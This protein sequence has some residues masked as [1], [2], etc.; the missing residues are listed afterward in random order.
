M[1]TIAIITAITGAASPS[2]AQ[3]LPPPLVL[4][5]GPAPSSP[6]SILLDPVAETTC[7]DTPVQ[8][9]YRED[10]PPAS[11]SETLEGPQTSVFRFA[12]AAD[13]RTRD[14]R[15]DGMAGS[16]YNYATATRGVT[17]QANLA[18][19]R[20]DGGAR[21]DCRLTITYRPTRIEEAS[22]S[23]LMRYYAVTRDRGPL[24]DAVARRL[25]GPG[26]NCMVPD[27]PRRR[28]Q[29][30]SHPDFELGQRPPPGGYAWTVVRWNVDAAGR[31]TDVETL[32]SSGD[33]VFD[34][35]ARRAMG[36]SRLHP[37]QP[38][39]GCVYNFYRTGPNLSAPP[40][41]P[42]EERE[43]PLQQCPEA[44]TARLSPVRDLPYP[45][46]FRARGI[47]G[48][49]LVRFDIASWGQIGNVAV[50]E[51]QPAAA[52]G[53]AQSLVSQRRATPGFEAAIRCVQPVHYRMGADLSEDPFDETPER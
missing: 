22:P 3:V 2:L 6:A 18:A 43:D 17:V 1:R 10:L 39:N 44:I 14:I 52:F 13:G 25:A 53:E 41:P 35:E 49:A 26:A 42:E 7:G 20:F 23:L 48:W 15:P 16:S 8:P 46:A 34:T 28:P 29:T 38:A 37:G 24:R 31:Y 47:E 11:A 40:I 50:L 45:P 36:D 12:V 21:S 5:H 4:T 30:T 19:W 32:G 51:A 27:R 9:A 33:A